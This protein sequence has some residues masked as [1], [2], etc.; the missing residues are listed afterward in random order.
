[1][2]SIALAYCCSV[3]SL[4]KVQ[5]GLKCCCIVYCC[6]WLYNSKKTV[7]IYSLHIQPA[8]H[9]YLEW[10]CLQ[11]L[12]TV[13]VLC[14]TREFGLSNIVQTSSNSGRHVSVGR[15][16]GYAICTYSLYP[17]SQTHTPTHTHPHTH[18]HTHTH[19][20][21]HAHT[22]TRT[23]AHT[24][25]HTHTRTHTHTHTHTLLKQCPGPQ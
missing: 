21:A 12:P 8:K 22:H 20:H 3:V 24:H 11:M 5:P 1:L 18:T 17:P 7:G 13:K 6:G 16:S 25:T 9:C 10:I 2:S 19:A 15:G 23:H 4:K 14:Q